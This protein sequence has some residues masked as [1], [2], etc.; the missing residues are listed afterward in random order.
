LDGAVETEQAE[1]AAIAVEPFVVVDH[2]PLQ[3]AAH[4][5]TVGDGVGGVAERRFDETA[6]PFVGVVV[7]VGAVL[8]D[9]DGQAGQVVGGLPVVR[10]H[11]IAAADV[12]HH[13]L[14]GDHQALQQRRRRTGLQCAVVYVPVVG[15]A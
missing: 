10:L 7:K 9:E 4:V 13:H 5:E 14:L 12:T 15:R 6:A 11:A 2:A 1:V 8:G 3:V